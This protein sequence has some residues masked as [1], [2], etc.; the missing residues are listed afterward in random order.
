M[1]QADDFFALSKLLIGEESL[2]REVSDAYLN[3]INGAYR[4][5]LRSLLRT[6]HDLVGTPDL[7]D[8]L[9]TELEQHPDQAEVA[10]QVVTIW[11]TSQFTKPDKSTDPPGDV[12]Q[13][14][15][16]LLWQVIRAHPPAVSTGPYGYWEFI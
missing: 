15:S 11:F 12:N 2:D 10:R 9:L 3:R 7:G 14:R 8:A 1:S 16:A 4:N 6:F 5:A 13:Y